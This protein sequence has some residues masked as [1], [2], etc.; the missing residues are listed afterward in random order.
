MLN[1][2]R[3]ITLKLFT[4]SS[5]KQNYIVPYRS[6]KCFKCSNSVLSVLCNGARDTKN[7]EELKTEILRVG[8]VYKRPSETKLRIQILLIG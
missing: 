5:M 6:L 7:E 1:D 3:R 2:L 8:V 4:F